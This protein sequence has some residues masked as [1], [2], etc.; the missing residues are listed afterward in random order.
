M[1]TVKY[2]FLSLVA[3]QAA[4]GCSGGRSLYMTDSAKT[5]S[6]TRDTENDNFEPL[7]ISLDGIIPPGATEVIVFVTVS[8]GLYTQTLIYMYIIRHKVDGIIAQ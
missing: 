3:L 1:S 5:Y 2:A 6:L 4:N 8:D 7:T